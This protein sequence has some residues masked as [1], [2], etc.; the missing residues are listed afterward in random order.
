MQEY[1]FYILYSA[2]LNKFYIGY[3]ANL[4]ER[5]RKHNSN[6]KGFTGRNNDWKIV[7]KESYPTKELAYERERQIKKW[8]SKIRIQELIA[9]N[10]S[11]PPD[12]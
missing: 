2:I 1:Y 7:Y 4:E 5:L 6:H 3:T 10:G 9:R 12:L 8:K 11:D